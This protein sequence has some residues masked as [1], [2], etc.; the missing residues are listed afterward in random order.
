MIRDSILPFTYNMPFLRAF[1]SRSPV[2]LLYHSVRQQGDNSDIDVAVLEED[3][4]ALFA[5][6]PH[7]GVDQLVAVLKRLAAG[8]EWSVPPLA[9]PSVYR[10]TMSGW[11]FL[12]LRA[13]LTFQ[14]VT[15]MG[16]GRSTASL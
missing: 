2:V 12:M 10:S 16:N 7:W 11:K 15:Q 3:Y 13:K 6:A 4:P 14:R 1:A 8:E 9:G 5:R